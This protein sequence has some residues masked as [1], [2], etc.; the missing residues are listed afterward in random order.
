[1]II[2]F[3]K[4]NGNIFGTVNGRVHD[5]HT[6]DNAMI[7]PSGIEEKNIGKFIVPYKQKYREETQDVTE[8]RMT[9]KE[10]GKVERVKTGTKKVKVPAGMEPDV[11][12]AN[13]IKDIEKG[14][15]NIYNYRVKL[16]GGKFAGLEEK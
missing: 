15:K 3:N 7:K 16:N 12:F 4:K 14:K 6:K 5:Q 8:L 2:F 1:M 13:L 11:P 9:N 10:T